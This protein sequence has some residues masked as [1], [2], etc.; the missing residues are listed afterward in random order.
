ME[1]GI[2]LEKINRFKLKKNN[3]FIKSYFTEK[4]TDYCFSKIN[5]EIHLCGIF[6]AKE[7]L[8]KTINKNVSLKKI[9]INHN[10]RGKPMIT[11]K[12]IDNKKQRFKVSISHS[13]DYATSCVLRIK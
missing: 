10:A 4:E 3:G 5:P 12:N 7:A 13:E 8:L 6:C 1:I 9:E 2:D 11:L